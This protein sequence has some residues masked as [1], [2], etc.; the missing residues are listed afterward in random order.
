M[1]LDGFN[2]LR[3]E[4]R[5]TTALSRRYG[6]H[7][8]SA[9]WM[10]ELAIDE[11]R[12]QSL[13]LDSIRRQ[14]AAPISQTSTASLRQFVSHIDI[15]LPTLVALKQQV[16]A[17]RS[18][19]QAMRNLCSPISRLP[20]EIL[21]RVFCACTTG[22]EVCARGTRGRKRILPGATSPSLDPSIVSRLSALVLTCS[23]HQISMDNSRFFEGNIIH[24]QSIITKVVKL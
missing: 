19:L 11:K 21:S 17:A 18:A 1:C 4:C 22:G 20:N 16:A 7:I 13:Y 12:V 6:S 23:S 24:V 10:D 15:V 14:R 2:V 8:S 5:P 9:S 3:V